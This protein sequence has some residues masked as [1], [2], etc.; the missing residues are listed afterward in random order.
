MGHKALTVHRTLPELARFFVSILGPERDYYLLAIVYG[1]GISLLSLATPISVQMLINTVAYTG[2][3]TPLVMLSLSLFV[4]LLIASL[5]NALRIHLMDL[6]SRRFYARMMSEMSLRTLFAVNPF[7][8]DIGK[9]ALFNR[10]FDIVVV[11][12]TL[13][14]LVV[15]GFTII[16]QMIVGM[17]LVSLYHPLFMAFNLVVIGLVWLVWLVWGKRAIGSALELSHRKHSAAAW[18]EELGG[19]NGFFKSERHIDDALERTEAVTA[20]YMSQHERHFRHH[21][22][23]TL[24][25]LLLFAAASAL[26]LGLGGWLV[27]QGEL[28]LG[29]L[30]AAELV[31]SVV[32][33]GISQL[34][35]YLTYFYDLCGAIEELSLFWD[36]EQEE[37]PTVAREPGAD[38]RLEFVGARAGVRGVDTVFDLTIASGARVLARAEHHEVQRMFCE[39]L[40]GHEK[41]EAGI[42]TIGGADLRGLGVRALRQDV[43]VLDRPNVVEMT[44][45][46]Y[47]SLSDAEGGPSILATLRAVGLETAIGQLEHGLDTMVTAT[48]WPLS[49]TE[50]MQLKLAAAIIGEP[51]VLVLGR[52]FDIMPDAQLREA[53]DLVQDES[54]TTVI[55]FSNRDRDLACGLY[56]WFGVE[57]QALYSSPEA[58]VERTAAARAALAGRGAAAAPAEG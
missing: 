47:L 4:L 15:G 54:G 38:G 41:P 57:G 45:R 14:N 40:K 13:P 2:M 27:I 28:T 20:A 11:L 21:F 5:L 33:V 26:L 58:L 36:V 46:E 34:G 7:F 6:F 49:I 42:I 35:L 23:Q 12:K 1:I 31:L 37:P 43:I 10:Y 56:A 9:G 24:S 22:A 3:T 8:D 17:V 18:L 39:L 16:L 53:L 32:F 30:V 50:V 48:G 44:L 55:L 52:I 51:R 25:L 19:S 29:Q